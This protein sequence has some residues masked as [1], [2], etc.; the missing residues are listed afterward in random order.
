MVAVEG[1]C[2]G[3]GY[4]IGRADVFDVPIVVMDIVR[5]G[6]TNEQTLRSDLDGVAEELHI[7]RCNSNSGSLVGDEDQRV[8]VVGRRGS[9]P[10]LPVDLPVDKELI[11]REVLMW[12]VVGVPWP[13]API[14]P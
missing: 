4:A 6:T 9:I 14:Q 1:V 7:N 13:T 8:G 5:S 10:C 3:S 12:Q 11:E 2:K